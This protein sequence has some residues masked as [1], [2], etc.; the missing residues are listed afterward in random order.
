MFTHSCLR[1]RE[2][3]DD[4]KA[5]RLKGIL[6]FLTINTMDH[7]ATILSALETMRLGELAKKEKTSVFKALAYKKAMDEIRRLGRPIMSMADV[8]GVGAIGPKIKEKI[9]EILETGELAAA[10]RV[11]ETLGVDALEALMTIHGIGPV[12]ARELVDAGIR[13]V[14]ALSMALAAN[15]GILNDT[16][17]MGLKY[18]EFASLRIPRAEMG[19]HAET[20]MDFLPKELKGEVVGSYRRGLA[21]SGDI[22]LLLTYKQTVSAERAIDVFHTYLDSLVDE[23]YI[24]DELVSGDKKWMGYVKVGPAG[25]PRRLD[26]LLTPPEE[27]PYAVLYFTGSDR[28]NVA[29]RRWATE[30]GY[31]LNEHR[32]E[33]L[34]VGADARRPGAFAPQRGVPGMKDEKDI[35]TFLGLRYVEPQDRVDG[36]QITSVI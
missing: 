36:H 14:G 11:K 17:K 28:F 32:M 24:L 6:E 18:G 8:E 4:L 2:K 3:I 7:T 10:I 13:S 15:P 9:R 12:K 30:K 33:L 22:D 26:V 23:G 5:V 34:G 16:Q 25:I 20:L 31:T 35:F 29:M 27:Y 21:T 19:V 1:Q